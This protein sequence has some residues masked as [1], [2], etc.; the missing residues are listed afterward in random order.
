V[1]VLPRD[2]F[3]VLSNQIH[4][5]LRN[6]W[7]AM[8]LKKRKKNSRK[9]LVAKQA[10]LFVASALMAKMGRRIRVTA[11]VQRTFCALVAAGCSSRKAAA[12]A[13]L[14]EG[15]VRSAAGRDPE[16][17]ARV[18]RAESAREARRRRALVRTG[19]RRYERQHVT[20]VTRFV[21]WLSWK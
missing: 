13:G 7:R 11:N 14:P 4:R 3:W 21:R 1:A 9:V 19:R 20:L 8:G 2:I 18:E 16:F 17:A 5:P 12:L 15:T 10:K 6:R